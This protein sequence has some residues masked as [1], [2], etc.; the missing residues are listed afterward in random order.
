MQ[1]FTMD[2]HN[3]LC[4]LILIISGLS[5]QEISA[6][7]VACSNKLAW[8]ENFTGKYIDQEKWRFETHFDGKLSYLTDSDVVVHSGKLYLTLHNKHQWNKKNLDACTILFTKAKYNMMYGKIEIRA[9][10]PLKSGCW[11]AIWIRPQRELKE[12]VV[13]EIDLVEWTSCFNRRTFQANFHLWGEFGGKKNNH[14]QYPKRFTLKK[15]TLTSYHIYSA[16]WDTEKM[17]IK[18]DDNL[19]GVW[20]KKDYLFW[21]FDMPQELCLQM[22]FGGWAASCSADDDVLPQ[23]TIVDWVKYYP[24]K[25]IK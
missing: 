9:K 16:E 24:L 17:I 18:I 5:Q 11:P 6:Q 8:I 7:T 20:W 13:P 21:P 14:T 12:K 2:K 23:A 10:I 1:L 25:N 3:I 15:G 4:F 22:A 19:V